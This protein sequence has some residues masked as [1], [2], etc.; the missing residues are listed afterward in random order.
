MR[1]EPTIILKRRVAGL[2]QRALTEF[3]VD[4]CEAAGLRGTTTVLVTGSHEIRALNLRFK[5]ENHATDVL[6]FPAPHFINGFAGDIAISLDV[7]TRNAHAL[8][9]SVAEEVRILALHG[10]LHLAGYDHEDDT[11]EMARWEQTLRQR[12]ALPVALIERSSGPRQ[13][14]V[15]R[16]RLARART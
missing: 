16:V 11:G 13:K 15:S 3:V 4:A 14:K 6:S 8:Q 2:S 1:F 9:H 12:F 10:I 7:A 5:G